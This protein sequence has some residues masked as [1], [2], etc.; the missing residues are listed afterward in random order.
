MFDFTSLTV[1]EAPLLYAMALFD[2]PLSQNG[3]MELLQLRRQQTAAG[4]NYE[5]K[6]LKESIASLSSRLL[7]RQQVGLGYIVREDLRRHIRTLSG[8]L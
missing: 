3:L 5:V 7:I 2:A 6:H 1:D 8:N 4:A